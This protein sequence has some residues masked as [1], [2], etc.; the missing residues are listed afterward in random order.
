MITGLKIAKGFEVECKES[1][2]HDTDA[3]AGI[4]SSGAGV[5]IQ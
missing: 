4:D 5:P 1:K 2:T 3:K